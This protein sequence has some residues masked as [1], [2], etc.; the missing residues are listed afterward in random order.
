ML[1]D[2]PLKTFLVLAAEGR[3]SKAAR[4]LHR[5]QP[6]L[7]AQL[8]RL[9]EELG[10]P[11]FHRTPKGLVLTEAGQLFHRYADSA[12]TALA[13]GR[14]AVKSLA[15]LE[16][17]ELSVGGGATVTTYLLPPVLRAFHERH[18]AIRLRVREQG[19][20]AVVDGVLA[21]ELD[22]GVVTLPVASDRLHIE[23]WLED[24]LLLIA[25]PGHRLAHR[26][27]FRWKDLEGLS[28]V[29]FEPGTAVRALIDERL[30]QSGV[31][32]SI[33]MELRSIDA[34]QQMVAAGIGAGFV[35]RWSLT[36]EHDGRG[37]RGIRPHDAPLVR[38]L[39]LVWRLDRKPSPAANAF[40]ELL[41]REAAR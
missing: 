33:V 37:V 30:A 36:R 15:G 35:S 18:P 29:L 16:R 14:E 1:D 34:I 28:L 17:G 23:P 13:D 11:L 40:L 24:E 2:G 38:Q 4:R 31:T 27:T 41:P 20:Q 22:L 7:S 19:S 6:A 26:K 25:P 8:A 21:G 12:L 5:T 10:A 3:M 9:E 39:G 32:V